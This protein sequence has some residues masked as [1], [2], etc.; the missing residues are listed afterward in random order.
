LQ[1]KYYLILIIGKNLPLLT[2]SH[3]GN[4]QKY[5]FVKVSIRNSNSNSGLVINSINKNEIKFDLSKVKSIEYALNF[6][7]PEKYFL[8]AQFISKYYFT[9]LNIVLKSFYK[10]NLLETVENHTNKLLTF[11]ISLS[12]KQKETVKNLKKSDISLLFGDTGSGKT[13]IYKQLIYENL[14]KNKKSIFLVPEISLVPQIE[15]R[16]KSVFGNIVASWH[17]KITEK[18]KKIVLNKIYNEEIKIVIG[19]RSAL[20]LPLKNIG[21]I[22]V[23]EEHSESYISPENPSFNT[24]DIAIYLGNLL[25]VQVV[26]GTATPSLNSYKKF[27]S[28]RLKGNFFDTEKKIIFEKNSY[29]LSENILRSIQQTVEKNQQV[30]VFVPVRG[31]F[32][33]LIC[34]NCHS[35]ISCPNCS[36]GMSIYVDENKLKCQYC[37]Y[38]ENIPH[39]CN[40]CNSEELSSHKI[41]TVEV[42]N[43]IKK[44][45][46]IN[47]NKEIK[48]ERFDSNSMT[49][50]AKF[51]KTLSNFSSQEINI[52]VGTQMLSKGHDYPNVTLTVISGLDQGFNQ[53]DFSAYEKNISLIVQL[54]GRTGRH[55]NGTIIIQTDREKIIKKYINNYQVFLEDELKHRNEL[56]PPFVKMPRFLISHTKK[57]TAEE[58]F[59]KLFVLLEELSLKFDFEIFSSG[60]ANIKK[61]F[62]KYRFQVTLRIKSLKIFF[63]ISESVQNSE[64]SKYKKQIKIEIN[65]PNYN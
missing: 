39:Q 24:R 33:N 5:Q 19:P 17:S 30:I 15:N 57:E 45:L 13:H 32:K 59:R 37:N 9:P 20:F 12:E 53:A 25:K 56:Y 51:K 2:Y 4:L 55:Q 18:N 7:L 38:T 26:L 22:I 6:Y 61:L 35:T 44:F 47:S 42:L 8:T 58:I 14:L 49:T 36:I 31:N 27:N 11:N 29:E 48:I 43:Q 63:L 16:L 28:V 62:N 40:N 46:K 34:K 52:L 3:Y 10:F 41:G 54:A 64:L 65:P 60:E 50:L 23:D 1:I 21:L